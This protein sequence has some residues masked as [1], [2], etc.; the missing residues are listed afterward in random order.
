M[1]SNQQPITAVTAAG[2]GLSAT[3]NLRF[4]DGQLQQ[5]FVVRS[6]S[7]PMRSHIIWRDV[8]SLTSQ[9]ERTDHDQ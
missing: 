5:E 4:M 7:F 8:P 6:L 2:E 3:G 9:N 1:T